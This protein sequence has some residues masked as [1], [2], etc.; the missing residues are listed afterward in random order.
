VRAV[1]ADSCSAWSAVSAFSTE[2]A[3]SLQ[4]GTVAEAPETENPAWLDWLLP[5]GGVIMLVFL[6]TMIV[7]V[8]VMIVLVIKVSKL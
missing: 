5:M 7:M 6:L 8:I 1:S 4:T 2:P 3:P